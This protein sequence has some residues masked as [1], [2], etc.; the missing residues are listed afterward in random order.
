MN[1]NFVF[2]FLWMVIIILVVLQCLRNTEEGFTP[3]IRSMYRP[4]VRNM[5]IS[6]ESYTN[7]YNSDYLIGLLR[8][9]GVY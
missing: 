3:K 1:I 5:R 6:L 4:Y 9:V 7:K 8:K 2:L